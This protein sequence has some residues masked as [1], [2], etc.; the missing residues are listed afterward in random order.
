MRIPLLGMTHS[1]RVDA[2]RRLT[3]ERPRKRQRCLRKHKLFGGATEQ[4]VG[5]FFRCVHQSVDHFTY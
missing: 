2:G 1:Q 3:P 4:A 5:G